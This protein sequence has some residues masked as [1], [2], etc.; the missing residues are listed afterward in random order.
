MMQTGTD[1]LTK[2]RSLAMA[3]RSSMSDFRTKNL[4]HIAGTQRGN[5]AFIIVGT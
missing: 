5:D 1:I 4:S 3:R 2:R